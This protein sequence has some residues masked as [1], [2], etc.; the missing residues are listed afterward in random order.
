MQSFEGGLC[1]EKSR[2]DLMCISIIT[3]VFPWIIKEQFSISC[4]LG[5]DVSA[6]T[7]V[8]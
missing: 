6:N 2:T 7:Y 4:D 1:E 8:I 3:G 5:Y